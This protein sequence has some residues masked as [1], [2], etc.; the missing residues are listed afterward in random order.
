MSEGD[1]VEV[2]R[3]DDLMEARL[4]Q[5]RLESEGIRVHIPGAATRETLD[6]LANMWS[7]GV[8]IKVHP[9]DAAEARNIL[10][11]IADSSE[12]DPYEEGSAPED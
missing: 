7:G 12:A 1:L 9:D 6:G 4:I 8:P 3:A 2:V 5:G 10:E 11:A